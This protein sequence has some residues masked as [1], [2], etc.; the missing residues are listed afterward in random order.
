LKASEALLRFG[1][2][3]ARAGGDELG[4]TRRNSNAT[5]QQ[6]GRSNVIRWFR[7]PWRPTG[8]RSD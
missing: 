1:L 4:R 7:P 5:A 2:A 8:A 6:I 3:D